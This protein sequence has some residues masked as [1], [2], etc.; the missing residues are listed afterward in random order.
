MKLLQYAAL[1]GIGMLA[2]SNSCS[3]ESE[4]SPTPGVVTGRLL[5]VETT[6]DVYAQNPRPRWT[7]D[8][9]PASL[10]GFNGVM[11]QQ[12][13]AFNLPANATYQVG[14]AVSFRY[15]LVP[16]AQQTPWKTSYEWYSARPMPAGDVALPEIIVSD[17]SK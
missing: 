9:A 15:Q 14:Q 17:N 1:A 16:Y 3:K 12:A 6:W 13:K 5:K 7:I 8:L 11:Y 4:V 2:M 10:E